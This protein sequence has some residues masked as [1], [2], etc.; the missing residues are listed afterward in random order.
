MI[1][2]GRNR[3]RFFEEGRSGLTDELTFPT[4]PRNHLTDKPII[5]EGII[6]GNQVRRMLVDCDSSSEIMYDHCFTNLNVDVWSRLKRCRD[7][8]VAMETNRKTLWEYR[9]LE[10][11]QAPD[12]DLIQDRYHQK[13]RGKED[14]K[15]VF[16]INKELL[17]QYITMGTTLTTDCKKLLADILRENIDVFAW[18]GSERTA[19][20]RFV[21][22]HQLK[23]SPLAEPVVH[24]RR[25]MAP[26]GRLAL[27]E[28]ESSQIR[29]AED[30]EEKIGFHTEDG[31]TIEEGAGMG[32]MLVN[33]E[34]KIDS[35]AIRLKFNASNH[36][37]DCG[38]LL[39]RLAISVSKGMKDLH[40]FMDSPKLAAQTEGNHMLAT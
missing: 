31:E 3:K 20:T 34:E 14:A 10:R 24:K 4:I 30:D 22:E 18:A 9:Q 15:E 25:H 38:A 32:I 23:V 2:E 29:M 6:K 1:R 28:K 37:M 8:L 21:I 27:K 35:Y 36:A 40:V 39:A 33:L 13:K 19:V 5:L 26:E 17:D 16:T 12:E 11:V 7:L